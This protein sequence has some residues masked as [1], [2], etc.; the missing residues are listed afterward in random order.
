MVIVMPE[1]TC[2]NCGLT[3]NMENR[4]RIDYDLIMSAT[5]KSAT[6]TQ[7]LHVTK[8]SRK[9]L[10]IRLKE[11]CKNGAIIKS[12]GLYKLGNSSQADNRSIG[13]LQVKSLASN[14]SRAFHDRRLRAAVWTLM[15]VSSFSVSGYALAMY[16]ASS[17]PQQNHS[18]PVAVGYSM[19]ALELSD[20]NDLYSWQAAIS[21]NATELKVLQVTPGNFVGLEFPLFYNST[22]TSEG[23]LLVGGCLVGDVAGKSGNGTLATILF[24]CFTNSYKAPSIVP[25]QTGF[26]TFLQDSELANIPL[27]TK[28][29][30]KVLSQ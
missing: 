17:P 8:L 27:G 2:P 3:I 4:R 28:L 22:D 29:S 23:L 9:T 12:D 11:M 5:R 13:S 6:F 7:L 20:V 1:V 10:S 21:F 26:E 16:Y 30:L 25:E 19:M 15:L 18:E 24:E 14:L